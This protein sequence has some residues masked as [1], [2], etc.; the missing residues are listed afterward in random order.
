MNWSRI[1]ATAL[2]LLVL[3]AIASSL[4]LPRTE[5]ILVSTA[6]FPVGMVLWVVALL[7]S[8]EQSKGNFQKGDRYENF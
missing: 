3:V 8:K 2:V 4:Y 5:V 7:R 6:L 1:A